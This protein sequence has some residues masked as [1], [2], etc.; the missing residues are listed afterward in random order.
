M[1]DRVVRAVFAVTLFLV[2]C[3]FAF[4]Q[5]WSYENKLLTGEDGMVLNASLSGTEVKV[6]GVSKANGLTTID[7]RGQVTGPNGESYTIVEATGISMTGLKE[8]YLPETIRVLGSFRRNA[9]LEKVEPFL[10]PLLTS[11]PN[12][13][14]SEC[15]KLTGDLRIS[16]PAFTVIPTQAFRETAIT[17][18]DFSD[19]AIS[20]IEASAFVSCKSLKTVTPFLPPTLSTIGEYAFSGC[21][22]LEGDLKFGNANLKSTGLNS[23][24]STKI[25]SVDFGNS[26]VETIASSFSSCGSITNITPFLPPTVKTLG[27]AMYAF[28]NK[29]G[30]PWC[31]VAKVLH[32]N[33]PD[34]TSIPFG[35]FMNMP[36]TGLDLTGCGVT[37]I[38]SYAFSTCK[39]LKTVEPFLPPSVRSIGDGSFTNSP[40]T[41]ELTM[42]SQTAGTIG[43]SAFA[44]AP[45]PRINLRDANI[46]S[47]GEKAFYKCGAKK[48]V[49]PAT[50]TSLGVS[51]LDQCTAEEG[52][53]FCGPKPT[54]V[55]N[56]AF[57]TGKGSCTGAYFFPRG[58]KT[59]EDYVY[60]ASKNTVTDLTADER[61]K[62]KTL[63]PSVNR[64]PRQKVKM[65][66]ISYAN[67]QYL[68]W[69]YPVPPGMA[70]IVR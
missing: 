64:G 24:A 11:L 56:L 45:L 37:T 35:C 19:V 40:I 42:A 60:D 33:S 52:F 48:V 7:L 61:A 27:E 6:T 63:F 47:L 55:G 2:N 13:V 8:L 26:P 50:V 51:A 16:S 14:F 32:L 57:Y 20:S 10:P 46:T 30:Y 68:C 18:V 70:V 69:W 3:G 66:N 44:N 31:K 1:K 9:T 15:K 41:N 12:Y 39:D 34:L 65:Q 21:S 25:T 54:T 17:S 22:A 4:A 38:G 29:D 36:I 59:W 43:T 62:F 49:L 67:A 23:F 28:G 58:D 5:S 53:W